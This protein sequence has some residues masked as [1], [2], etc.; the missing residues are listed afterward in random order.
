MKYLIHETTRQQRQDYINELFHC[1]HGDCENCG[2][3]QIFNGTSPQ[4]V[5]QDYIDGVRE[6][7]EISQEW[8]QRKLF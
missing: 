8:N 5:F 2:V 3:C 1:H 4:S 7:Q 6:F